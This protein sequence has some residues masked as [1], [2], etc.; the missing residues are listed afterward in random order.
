MLNV[1]QIMVSL[2]RIISHP[3]S[4]L[5]NLENIFLGG[6]MANVPNIAERLMKEL[7][8]LLPPTL[9]PKVQI[10]TKNPAYSQL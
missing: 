8:F 9:E 7:D 1:I 6:G 3:E 2:L 10:V 4:L 5:R